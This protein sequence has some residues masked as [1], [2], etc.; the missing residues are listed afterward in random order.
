MPAIAYSVQ[1]KI[2]FLKKLLCVQFK[3]VFNLLT[4]I[5]GVVAHAKT[6]KGATQ[7]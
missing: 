6:K 3:A 7:L 1:N 2:I 5:D 4:Y